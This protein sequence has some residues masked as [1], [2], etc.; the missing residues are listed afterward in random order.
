MAPLAPGTRIG[1]YRIEFWLGRG[2]MGVVYLAFD[3]PLERRVALKILAP[4]LAA[5]VGFQTRFAAEARAAAAVEHTNLLP[6]YEAGEAEGRLYLAMRYVPGFDLGTILAR[7]GAL[8]VERTIALV[9]QVAAGLD[10]AHAAGLVHRDVKP[11]NVLIGSGD[12]AYL[13]DF[14]LARAAAAAAGLTRPGQV[15]VGSAEYLAP[16]LLDGRAADIR[17]DTYALACL[18]FACLTGRPPF[19]ANDDVT[20]LYAHAHQP[21]PV[22]TELQPNLSPALDAV[23]ARGLAKDPAERHQSAGEFARRLAEGA[24]VGAAVPPPALPNH[25]SQ[26]RLR[27]TRALGG[28]LVSAA[29]IVTA[30]SFTGVMLLDGQ[31]GTQDAPSPPPTTA[32]GPATA[33]ATSAP[34]ASEPT[35]AAAV[36]QVIPCAPFQ[37]GPALRCQMQEIPAG[38][39]KTTEFA[40]DIEFTLGPGWRL[41]YPENRDFV[42]LSRVDRPHSAV[43]FAVVDQLSRLEP[44]A[45]PAPDDD[46]GCEVIRSEWDAVSSMD[47]K[48]KAQPWLEVGPQVYRYFNGDAL[49]IQRDVVIRADSGC[50]VQGNLVEFFTSSDGQPFYNVTGAKLRFIDPGAIPTRYIIALEAPTEAEFGLFE[51]H[52]EALLQSLDLPDD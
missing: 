4:E 15:A 23:L 12:H 1:R 39:Y 26:R 43:E 34:T 18:A 7:E 52:A 10:A 16:E 51:P 8:P 32:A 36:A 11:A 50:G 40:Y 38:R 44:I 14:G 17:S 29:A 27:P 47:D 45:S 20:T 24:A 19:Q 9:R 2:G 5:D 33:R 28:L 46:F 41:S 48:L 31:V 21:P 42:H 35:D 6:I 30:V 25:Q 22:P 37:D 49:L 3:E 13:A